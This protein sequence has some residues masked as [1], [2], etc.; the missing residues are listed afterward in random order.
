MIRTLNFG[1]L[2][3]L[4]TAYLL[5]PVLAYLGHGQVRSHWVKSDSKRRFLDL[6]L[7]IDKVM[8]KNQD[9]QFRTEHQGLDPG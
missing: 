8:F 3:A 5:R 4:F 6:E 1:N 9:G 2:F 7:V